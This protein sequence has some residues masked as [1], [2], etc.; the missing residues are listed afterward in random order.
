MG[1]LMLCD[2]ILDDRLFA[3]LVRELGLLRAHLLIQLRLGFAQRSQ[4]RL[5]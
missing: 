4:L 2:A 5:L 3:C 1:Y